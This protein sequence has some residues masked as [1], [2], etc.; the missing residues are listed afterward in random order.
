[1]AE[2]RD[3]SKSDNNVKYLYDGKNLKDANF[4]GLLTESGFVTCE[5]YNKAVAKNVKS[6]RNVVMTP[7]S[8]SRVQEAKEYKIGRKTFYSFTYK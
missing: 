4:V 1:M 5:G 2:F 6:G 8:V 7:K 3:S